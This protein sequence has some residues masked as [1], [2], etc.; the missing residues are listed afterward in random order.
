[1]MLRPS[2]SGCKSAAVGR[3]MGYVG[4]MVESGREGSCTYGIWWCQWQWVGGRAMVVSSKEQ[5]FG[6]L[7]KFNR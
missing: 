3:N 4:V 1:M 5:A 7:M 2:A 6:L